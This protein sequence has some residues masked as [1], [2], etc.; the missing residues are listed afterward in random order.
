M[1]DIQP[2][3]KRYIEYITENKRF[4]KKDDRFVF[5]KSVINSALLPALLE[6]L[7]CVINDV[8]LLL[9]LYCFHLLSISARWISSVYADR[10]QTMQKVCRYDQ[11]QKNLVVVHKFDH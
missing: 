10:A 9:K 11:K 1:I 6:V 2:Y 3:L 5:L 8:E 4:L 7:L